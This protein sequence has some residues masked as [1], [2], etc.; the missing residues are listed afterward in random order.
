MPLYTYYRESTGEYRDIFQSMNDIHE[1]NGE[2]GDEGDWKRV[3]YSPN[4]SIDSSIDPSNPNDFVAKTANKKGTMGDL[5]D[6]SK[7]L[8]E[9]RAS[10]YGGQDPL[11]KSYFDNY[12][13]E[14]GGKRHIAESKKTFEKNGIKV[15]FD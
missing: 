10:I 12:A 5:L 13:K 15:D 1:Y 14:R 4:M 11:K 3:Y 2:N 9:K 6:R 8:S 7:E